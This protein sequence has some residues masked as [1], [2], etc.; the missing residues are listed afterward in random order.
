MWQE[1]PKQI[2]YVSFTKGNLLTLYKDDKMKVHLVGRPS[3]DWSAIEKF[4]N[5]N[6]I[7]KYGHSSA[8][9]LCEV[10]GR[11]CYM[12]FEKPRPGGNSAYLKHILEVG[13]G[14]VLEHACWNFI[15]EG[16]SRSLTHELV[17]HRAGWS[18][19]QLSQRY[20]DESDVKFICPKLVANDAYLQQTY[21]TAIAY[22][23]DAYEKMAARLEELGHKRKICRQTARCV[24]PNATETKIF[25]TVNAR[26]LRN[27]FE[28]RCNAG[29][30]TEIHALAEKMLKIMQKEAPNIFGDYTIDDEGCH[31][32]YRKV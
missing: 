4:A 8:E 11:T 23:R 25:C 14:S 7:E 3:I 31:T 27:F 21:N 20:V 24:L 32:E 9:S 30:D 29:A 18:Y 19:S 5:H 17:R 16:V 2:R 26:A 10:A 6:K 22:I 13:H 1:Y 28:L 12:S 15:I